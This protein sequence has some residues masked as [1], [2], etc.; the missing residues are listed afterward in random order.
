MMLNLNKTLSYTVCTVYSVQCTVYSVQCT[1]YS[2][3]CSVYSV[4][5]QKNLALTP[6]SVLLVVPGYSG[7]DIL[8]DSQDHLTV[9]V[10]PGNLDIK[11]DCTIPF[12]KTYSNCIP[13][14]VAT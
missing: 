4:H 8:A 12:F 11:S 5:D 9:N 10:D 1:V 6:C 3:Q 7:D 2:V 13:V 14:K